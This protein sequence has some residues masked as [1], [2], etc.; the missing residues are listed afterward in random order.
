[1]SDRF[2]LAVVGGGIVGLATARALLAEHPGLRLVIL[3]KEARLASHQTGPQQRRHPLGHLLQAR[4]AQGAA[5]RRGRAADEGLLRGAR[6]PR[7]PDRQGDRRHLR[8]RAAAAPDALRAR[9]R[10]RRPGPQAPRQGPPPRDRASRRGHP[11]DPLAHHLDRRLRGGRPGPRA[12]AA[13]AGHR[14]P[15]RS[16]GHARS[17][18]P[19]RDSTCRPH[20]DPSRR[21]GSSTAPGS[22]PTSWPGSPAPAPACGSSRSGASTT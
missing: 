14:H 4:L 15:D 12:G 16:P 20:P 6:D 7:R 8:G 22:T 5:L 18:G 11:R 13:H 1:M 2:D 19:T 21:A 3:E 9:H 10:Q 17:S